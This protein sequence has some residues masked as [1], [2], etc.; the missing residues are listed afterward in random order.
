MSKSCLII[1]PFL[2]LF[3]SCKEKDTL[4]YIRKYKDGKLD[5]EGYF[6]ND[7]TKIGL[8][9]TFFI[10]GNIKTIDNYDSLGNLN[11]ESL[12]FYDNGKLWQ[13]R[14]FRNDSLTND[15]FEY[16]PNG[17]LKTKAYYFLNK[18]VGDIFFYREDGTLSNYNFI[19]FNDRNLI[20]GEYSR[21]IRK[22]NILEGANQFME[23]SLL[24]SSDN[25]I[26]KDSLQIYL[27]IAHVPF[28]QAKVKVVEL[29][30]INHLLKEH[31]ISDTSSF[32]NLKFKTEAS[33]K[34][35]RI[36]GTL[37]DSVEGKK[38]TIISDHKIETIE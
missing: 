37:Y 24:V 17:N 22:A 21:G 36:I 38:K 10:N 30:T 35:L 2:F 13:K 5:S 16:Y 34:L 27:L 29:D 12:F 23:D 28:T 32:Y 9:K 4:K 1:M 6:L 14:F 18:R 11:G 31:S 19:D 26:H 15:F 3:F 20:Y 8:H 33:L 25:F 7:T